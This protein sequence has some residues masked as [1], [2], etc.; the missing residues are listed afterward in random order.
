MKIPVPL[1]LLLSLPIL[2]LPAGCV[3]LGSSPSKEEQRLSRQ[4]DDAGIKTAVTSALLSKNPTKA[5][6]VEVRCFRGHVFLVGEADSE[7]RRF[8]L[9]AARETKGV[10]TVTPHWFPAG[11]VD[12]AADTALEA[13]IAEKVRSLTTSSLSQINIDVWGGH[14][15]LTGIL[16]DAPGVGQALAAAESTAGVKDVTSYLAVE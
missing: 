12:T 16:P 2:A 5:N 6:D 15:V 10:E 1:L 14:V 7:F 8:A 13:A 11:T 3:S 9:A 4:Y